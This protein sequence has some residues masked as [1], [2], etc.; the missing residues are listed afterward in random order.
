[1]AS[2]NPA[3]I[4]I[5]GDLV[6][7]GSNPEDY[8]TYKTETAA[9]SQAKIPIFPAL[10]NHE[11]QG[12]DKDLSPC[13][14]NWWRAAAPSGVRSFRWY[15]VTVGPK[16]LVLALDSDSSLKPGSEQRSWF[17]QQITH[18]DS[19]VEFVLVVLHYPPVRDPIFPRAKDEKEIA[20]YLSKHTRS[21]HA[22]IV[23]VGSHIHNY[24]RFR[25]DDITYLVSGGGG[26]KPV[27][28]LR[29]FGE[30]SKLDTAVNFH[31]I[32]FRLES[33]TLQGTMVR[34]DLNRPAESAWAEPDR[35]EV[36]AKDSLPPRNSGIPRAAYAPRS[37]Q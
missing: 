35:F 36:E 28:V 3:A 6:Y 26:A 10:G 34:F 24:E 11:F 5:G 23:V 21:L 12:C 32:R 7:E 2:E 8:E 9:W 16:V 31:Y 18:T 19:Q 27:P 15:S 13:L 14:E 4:F 29:L 37:P 20:R 22:R 30:L 17:E 1:M 25:R 33:G